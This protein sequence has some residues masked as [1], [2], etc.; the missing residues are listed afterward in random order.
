MAL[1]HSHEPKRFFDRSVCQSYK[2]II[3]EGKQI[4]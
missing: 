3:S 4:R 1:Y 2:K